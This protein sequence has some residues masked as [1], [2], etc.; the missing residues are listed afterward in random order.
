MQ[1]FNF[2]RLSLPIAKSNLIDNAINNNEG[3]SFLSSESTTDDDDE[4][5]KSKQSDLITFVDLSYPV[6]VQDQHHVSPSAANLEEISTK[7]VESTS[8]NNQTGKQ[9]QNK[10]KLWC[11]NCDDEQFTMEKEEPNKSSP[12]TDNSK[13]IKLRIP[14][15]THLIP[16]KFRKKEPPASSVPYSPATEN[17]LNT[18]KSIFRKKQ[19]LIANKPNQV[20]GFLES[21]DGKGNC[22]VFLFETLSF[23]KLCFF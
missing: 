3:D 10:R 8:T 9:I 21:L 2:T 14:I 18:P 19:L 12:N 20:C 6:I 11:G 17:I 4:S 16:L 22:H 5:Y 23:L 1:S 7:F 15:P 13:E